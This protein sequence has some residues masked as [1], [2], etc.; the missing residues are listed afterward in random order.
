MPEPGDARKIKVGVVIGTLE[1][2][3]AELDIVRN[4]PRLNLDEFEVGLL[5]FQAPGSLAPDLERQGIRVISGDLGLPATSANWVQR[6]L[7]TAAYTARVVPWIA[8]N[9]RVEDLDVIHFFLPNAYGYGMLACRLYGLR[10]KRAMSRLSLNIYHR[11]HRI[12]GWL[13]KT[14]FHRGLDVAIGNSRPILDELVAEGVAP[15]KVRLLHNGIDPDRYARSAGD[16]LRS[17]EALRIDSGAFTMVAVGNLHTY[18]GHRDLIEACA[19]VADR[20]PDGWRLLIAGRDEGGNRAV[21]EELAAERG[22]GDRVTLLGAFDDV[23][24]LL[25][26]ADV[27]VHPSHQEGLPNAIVEAMAASLPVVA[28][29]VGGIPEAVLARSTGAGAEQE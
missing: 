20:L 23:P 16:R 8:R 29:S 1:V 5:C 15:D 17:R 11:E 21:L 14:F 4:M 7:R 24:R 28:T 12:L 9:A 18:K 26:A 2:G 27:F 19:L 6:R 10:A 25:A 22:L 13:E 3:G